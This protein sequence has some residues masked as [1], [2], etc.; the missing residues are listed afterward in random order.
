M[1]CSIP[2][3][4][5][6]ILLGLAA[7]V[8]LGLAPGRATATAAVATMAALRERSLVLHQL[9]TGERL[10]AVYFAAGRYQPDELRRVDHLLRDW[11]MNRTRPTDPRLLDLL[12]ALNHRLETGSATPIEVVCGYRTPETNAMLR[13]RSESV[14]RNSLHM[15]AMAVDLR[16]PG[17][18]LRAVRNAALSLRGGGVGYYPRAD[19]VHIDTGAVRAW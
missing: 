16:I 7:P 8:L 15:R 10:K 12:V 3:G 18:S 6:Q 1:T 17:R 14:A 13:R 5:R 19:F 11:R 2:R 4:R 9:H